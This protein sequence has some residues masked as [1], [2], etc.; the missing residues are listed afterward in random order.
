VIIDAHCHVWPD[1]I[2]RQVLAT[3]PVGLTP[4][5]DGTIDGLRRT[6]DD[7]GIDRG[8]C[9]GVATVAKNVFRTNE[10]I[11]AV[12]R[13]RFYAFGTIHPELSVEDN[14]RS[15][16][17][18]NI[19]GVKLHPIFQGIALSDPRVR[20]IMEAVAEAD[21]VAITHAG[22]G[23][24]DAANQRG[25]PHE[26]LALA[27]AVPAL[28]LIACHYGG[29]HRFDEGTN[30]L[31]GTSVV[32]ETSWPPSMGDLD[33]QKVRDVIERHG[34]NRFVFGSDWPMADPAREIESIRG[35]GLTKDD[36]NALLGG[37]L[38]RLLDS[39]LNEGKSE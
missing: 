16:T 26:V 34:A 10:F 4:M 2:A 12:D 14:M 37:T 3:R 36:E 9:L 15:L 1:D 8:C 33:A 32:L 5:G 21:I 29:Y 31:V 18:N 30:C 19:Q 23:G 39:Q 24:D 38:E 28:K 11:G 20:E 13:S 27:Q 6:M 25:A 35:L 7:A 22:D 17:E